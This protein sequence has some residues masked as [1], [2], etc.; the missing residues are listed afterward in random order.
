MELTC[1]LVQAEKSHDVQW[2]DGDPGESMVQFLLQS[3]DL[4]TRRVEGVN[5]SF[6]LSQKAKEDKYSSSKTVKQRANSSFCVLFRPPMDWIR[7]THT[8]EGTLLYSS[9]PIQMLISFG[10]ALIDTPRIIFN[11]LSGHPWPS[12]VDTYN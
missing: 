1:V 4:K 7:P 3:K 6:S 11:Q 8:G 9:L 2:Q 12:Q 5:S 10:N